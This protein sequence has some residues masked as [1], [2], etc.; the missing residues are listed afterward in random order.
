[1]G[2]VCGVQ[3]DAPPEKPPVSPQPVPGSGDQ[4]TP[5]GDA[6]VLPK[7]RKTVSRKASTPVFTDT[8][9]SDGRKTISTNTSPESQP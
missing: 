7:Q 3:S 9:K 5:D 8:F 4:T 2:A 6:V 1:M